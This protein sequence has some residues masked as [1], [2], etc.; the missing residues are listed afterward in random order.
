MGWFGN[1]LPTAAQPRWLLGLQGLGLCIIPSPLLLQKWGRASDPITKEEEGGL[2]AEEE[3][4]QRPLGESVRTLVRVLE[5]GSRLCLFM[6]WKL[7]QVFHSLVGVWWLLVTSEVISSS[8]G[9][10]SVVGTEL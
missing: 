2:E 3:S 7:G 4:S 8:E 5:L 6:L 10:E 1:F 9:D